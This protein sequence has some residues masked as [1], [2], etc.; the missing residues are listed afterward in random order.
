M[1]NSSWNTGFFGCSGGKGDLGTGGCCAW[2]E[3]EDV[4]RGEDGGN[5]TRIGE[6]EE[7]AAGECEPSISIAD[8]DETTL[9]STLIAP[10][11]E[12]DEEEDDDEDAAATDDD[13]GD[14]KCN[15]DGDDD[16]AVVDDGAVAAM[17]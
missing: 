16:E 3:G 2:S 10:A 8:E 7:D 5:F 1:D 11:S 14:D 9:G 17:I 12:E 15:G 6:G 4:K 13:G